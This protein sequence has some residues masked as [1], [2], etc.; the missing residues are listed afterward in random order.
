[1]YFHESTSCHYVTQFNYLMAYELPKNYCHIYNN[2]IQVL[3][4]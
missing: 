3:V 2:C 4:V 1:M